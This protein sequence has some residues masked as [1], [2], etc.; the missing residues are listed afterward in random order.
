MAA[1]KAKV[2]LQERFGF[3][4]ADL[5]K[6]AHDDMIL[7]ADR[8]AADIAMLFLKLH[9]QPQV[10][11]DMEHVIKTDKGQIIGF[12]DLLIQA[13]WGESSER[14]IYI[15]A[16]TE[17]D[18]LGNL[19]RQIRMYQAGHIRHNSIFVVVAEDDRMADDLRRQRVEFLRYDPK[20]SFSFLGRT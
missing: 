6:P 1:P 20:K 14:H 8:N 13:N 17:L 18:T 16:K 3:L 9:K 12:V 4:D 2:T 19:L 10:W 5:K 7:W 11:T 15:E